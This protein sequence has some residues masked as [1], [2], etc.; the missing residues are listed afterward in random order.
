MNILQSFILGLIQGLTEF[1]P[2]SSSG[3]LILA[4]NA[5]GVVPSLSFEIALHAATLLAVLIYYRKTVINL[6]RH[7]FNAK[8]F[9]LL[10]ATAVTAIFAF[11][12]RDFA[13]V[14]QNGKLLPLFF[15]LTAVTLIAG[16][17]IKPAKR[18]FAASCIAVGIAQGIAVIPGLS[19]SGLTVSAGIMAGENREDA[20]ENSFLLSVPIIIG[21]SII[22]LFSHPLTGIETAPLIT[23][24]ITA[25]ISG[26]AALKLFSL[27]NKK[28]SPAVFSVYLIVL[29]AALLIIKY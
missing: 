2:V 26:L 13:D 16:S 17:L 15:M 1:L 14:M 24:L 21:S 29:S 4:C 11:A 10:S 25:F 7:P 5:I 3:H 18:H 22:E 19:R 28:A 23:G 6:V 20:T 9:Y 27:I 8:N 12:L